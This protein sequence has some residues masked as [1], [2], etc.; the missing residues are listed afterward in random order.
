MEQALKYKFKPLVVDGV[1]QQIEMPLVLHFTSK[2]GD[3]IP[4]LDDATTRKLVTGC[5]LPREISGSSLKRAKDRHHLSSAR[6]RRINDA[7]ELGS[8]DTCGDLVSAVPRLPFCTVQA[9]RPSDCLSRELD[10]YRSVNGESTARER[11]SSPVR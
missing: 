11:R 1:A 9:E 3:P 2:L 4:E 10:C 5:S 8:Q 7:G 6:G